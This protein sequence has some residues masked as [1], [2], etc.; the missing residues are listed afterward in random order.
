VLSRREAEDFDR[1]AAEPREVLRA[2]ARRLER[3]DWLCRTW[4]SGRAVKALIASSTRL[5]LADRLER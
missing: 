3:L 2:V 5:K 4:A 1:E